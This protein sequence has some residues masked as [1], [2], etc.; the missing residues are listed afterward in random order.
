VK[1][2]LADLLDIPRLQSAL[3]TLYNSSKIPSAII[4]N[5]GKIHTGSGWQDVCTKFHRGHHEARKRCIESD[6]YIRRHIN[7]ANPSVIYR[8]PHGLVDSA[9]PILVEGEHIGNVFT[10]QLFFEKPDIDYFRAQARAYGFDEEEYIDAVKKVPIITEQAM[11]ENLAFL[12]HLTGMLAEMGLKRAKE[13][14]AEQRLRESVEDYR[15][16][17]SLAS[18]G[19]FLLSLDGTLLEVNESFARMHGYSTREMMRMNIKDLGTPETAKMIPERV[20]RILA[21]EILTFEAEHYHKDGRVFKLE[22]SASLISYGGGSCIQCLHREITERKRA[23]ERLREN[24]EI[25]KRFMEHSPI[26]VFFKDENIRAL[27]LSKNYEALLG[28]PVE[29]MLGKNMN[30][31]FPS[32]FAKKMVEVDMRMIKEVKAI[33]LEE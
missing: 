17:F 3:D 30:D 14:E 6:S 10:G 22:V 15:A 1:H 28:M 19:I 33:T 32:G 11:R 7:E 4:D 25:F 18:D 20:R 29:E 27:R 12:A 26:Y 21:G 2:Q 9:T 13:Q 8:C 31:L 16:L 5:E 23:A 24:E